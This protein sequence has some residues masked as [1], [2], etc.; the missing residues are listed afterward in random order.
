MK[1]RIKKFLKSIVLE[2]Y[3]SPKVIEINGTQFL[4][5]RFD[6]IGYP[7]LTMN[8][9]WLLDLI[10]NYLPRI[11]GTV[12]DIGANTGQTLLKLKSVDKNVPYLGIEP[13]SYCIAYLDKLTRLNKLKDVQIIP[14]GVST[15]NG[16]LTLHSY[17]GNFDSCATV[18]EDY[19]TR[20][21]EKKNTIGVLN[22]ETILDHAKPEKVSLIKIDVEGGELEA[23]KSLIEIIQNFKPS[24]LIEVLPNY[25]KMDSRWQ[26]Q[27]ELEK[28]I[29]S[30]GY[31]IFRIYKT[32]TNILELAV[33]NDFGTH[34]NLNHCDYLLVPNEIKE[35]Y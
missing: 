20:R 28:L 27:L 17:S 35:N 3:F 9:L 31:S 25:G 1:Y 5:P 12:I 10:K 6:D 24:I 16:L 14:V 7:N 18:I 30:I 34:D 11:E 8:E 23:F 21:V 2:R 15:D 26:R 4:L 22:M 29:E 19:R 33:L 13:N 32:K